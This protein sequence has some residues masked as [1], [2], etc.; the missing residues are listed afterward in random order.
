MWQMLPQE[1]RRGG[2]RSLGTIPTGR[3]EPIATIGTIEKDPYIMAQEGRHHR[4]DNSQCTSKIPELKKDI[5]LFE[6]TN[7][8]KLPKQTSTLVARVHNLKCLHTPNAL[9]SS[10]SLDRGKNVLSRAILHKR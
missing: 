3:R 6:H 2:L 4:F 9:K 7:E 5:T 1:G 8:R 10:Q